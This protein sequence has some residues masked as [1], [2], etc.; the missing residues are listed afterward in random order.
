V[1]SCVLPTVEGVIYTYENS[2]ESISHG[3][4]IN[5]HQIVIES[6]ELGYYKSYEK[7]IRICRGNGKWEMVSDKLCLS[8]FYIVICML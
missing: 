2:N 1:N 4:L 7:S 6:C 5:R 3:T 8:K